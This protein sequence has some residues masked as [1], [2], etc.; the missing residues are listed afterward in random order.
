MM[1]EDWALGVFN[2]P[3]CLGFKNKP[4]D[5]YMRPFHLRVE[6]KDRFYNSVDMSPIVYRESCRETFIIKL[7]IKKIT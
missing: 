1:S 3:D 5:H 7:N 4:V 2:W 6:A